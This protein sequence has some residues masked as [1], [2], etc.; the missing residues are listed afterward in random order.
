MSD[1]S[2]T[3]GAGLTIQGARY[4]QEETTITRTDI[5][6]VS[7]VPNQFTLLVGSAEE[8]QAQATMQASGNV[9]PASSVV[10]TAQGAWEIAFDLESGNAEVVLTSGPNT[11]RH[12]LTVGMAIS[13][14]VKT[15]AVPSGDGSKVFED[16]II[17][18]LK[19]GDTIPRS[20]VLQGIYGLPSS[21]PIAFISGW[22]QNHHSVS[23][24]VAAD[25]PSPGN[26]SAK[27]TAIPP[28][29]PTGYVVSIMEKNS[30]EIGQS[31]P[32]VH[33]V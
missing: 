12:T 10:T 22:D 25:K 8:P 9:I 2:T 1:T 31:V 30:K 5:S 14:L 24:P 15:I 27:F 13:V 18:N 6:G 4:V 29:D 16:L 7:W 23:L 19:R 3:L 11:A 28:S 26:W 33:V 32:N 20:F 17:T 21:Q